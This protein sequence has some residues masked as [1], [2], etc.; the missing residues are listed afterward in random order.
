MSH[1]AKGMPFTAL[2]KAWAERDDEWGVAADAVGCHPPT[3]LQARSSEPPRVPRAGSPRE[4]RAPDPRREFGSRHMD[5][6]GIVMPP[7]RNVS[8]PRRAPG[9]RGGRA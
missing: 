2:T 9:R 3:N 5:F 4:A 1:R 8:A 7:L 6:G